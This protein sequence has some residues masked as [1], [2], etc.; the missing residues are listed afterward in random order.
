[1]SETIDAF[2]AAGAGRGAPA[3][4]VVETSIARIFLFPDWVLKLKKPVDFGFLDFTSLDQ[5]RWAL[6]RELAFNR[7]TAPDLYR[8][9]HPITRDAAGTLALGGQGEIVEWALEMRRF[10]DGALLADRVGDI[11]G[12]LAEALGREIARFHIRARPV[13]GPERL[14]YVLQSNAGL[15]RAQAERLG[16]VEPMLAATQA[17]YGRLAPMLAARGAGGFV[18]RCHGDLH[19]GNIFLEAGRP[20]LFDCVEFNDVLSEIDVLY[21]LAFLLMDLDFRGA[22]GAANRAL[23]GWLDEAARGFPELE[24]W[25][26]LAALPLF[27]AVRAAV[28]VHV[29]IHQDQSD[30]ARAYLAAAADH[31]EPAP[32]KLVAVGGR[33][34][35]GKSWRARE[36]A[37]GLGARPGAVVLRSDEIRKR[38]WGRAPLERLPPEAYVREESARVYGALFEAARACLAAGRAVV[39]DA[40]FLNPEERQ[41]AEA[42]AR[43]AGV[44]FEGLWMS[45]TPDLL[46]QRV[47][48][49]TG[50]A[51]DADLAVLERQL[52]MDVGPVAWRV[53]G[54]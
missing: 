54:E 13:V 33:S 45:A 28:R 35:S 53:E 31:L 15:L 17:A 8:A 37:P 6:E 16:D 47:S 42:V 46:R 2:A 49:R 34:G 20:V 38:L 44:E 7:E 4:R 36:I 14:G 50:D 39:L 40:A 29:T 30:T 9:V 3:E 10:P 32:L 5:R 23:N 52:A 21:D 11:D 51:S 26:G 41:G 1:V 48:A 24:L 25:Q 22:R 43:E 27:Q 18:R 12:D 19:L